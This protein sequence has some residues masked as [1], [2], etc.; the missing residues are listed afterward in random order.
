MFWNTL[1][2]KALPFF[3]FCFIKLLSLP[4]SHLFLFITPPLFLFFFFI[5]FSCLSSSCQPYPL[6][7]LLPATGL[8]VFSFSFFAYLFHF[9]G[10]QEGEE[11]HGCK[12]EK[13]TTFDLGLRRWTNLRAHRCSS[14]RV[15]GCFGAFRPA[16]CFSTGIAYILRRSPLFYFLLLFSCR[17]LLL[18]FFVV[19]FYLGSSFFSSPSFGCT[20]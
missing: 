7:F 8:F 4:L 5:L 1:C 2:T 16:Y 19:L 13:K 10:L 15:R 12:R 11:D 17:E 9:L 20:Q 6:F 18:F 3:F 14:L